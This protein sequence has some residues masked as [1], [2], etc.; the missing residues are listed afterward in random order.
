MGGHISSLELER[1]PVCRSSTY[2]VLLL[3]LLLTDVAEKKGGPQW[4]GKNKEKAQQ[5]THTASL[6]VAWKALHRHVGGCARGAPI[7]AV[8]EDLVRRVQCAP[9]AALGARGVHRHGVAIDR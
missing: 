6:H 9:A 4:R 2:L 3:L 7:G 8:D 5:A 1:W